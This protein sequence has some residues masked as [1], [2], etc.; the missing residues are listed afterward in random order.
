MLDSPDQFVLAQL[1]GW[2]LHCGPQRQKWSRRRRWLHRS[3][4]GCDSREEP[5]R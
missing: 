4:L 1:R 5:D 3:T 2:L